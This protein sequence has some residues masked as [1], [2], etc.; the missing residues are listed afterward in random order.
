M[1]IEALLERLRGR[2]G[3]CLW[4]DDGAREPLGATAAP[5]EQPSD[6]LDRVR[7]KKGFGPPVL[8]GNTRADSPL[9]LAYLLGRCEVAVSGLGGIA[10]RRGRLM[11]G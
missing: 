1:A 4:H 8:L 7:F 2:R 5:T 3:P 9:A 6:T 11:L 10:R